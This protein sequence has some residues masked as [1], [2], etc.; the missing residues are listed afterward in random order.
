MPP[1]PDHI[2]HAPRK[3]IC[4]PK[5]TAIP[6]EEQSEIGVIAASAGNHALALAW[7]GKQM[8]IPVTVLMPT[9]APLAKVSRCRAFGA[10]VVIHG[11]NIG[12]AKLLAETDPEFA[13]LQYINGYD[14]PEIV[15]GAG[16]MGRNFTLAP[17]P[18]RTSQTPSAGRTTTS[19]TRRRWI[20]L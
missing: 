11:A 1:L 20:T 14:D 3:H 12:E 2:F 6:S 19:R 13:G 9:L 5:L 10:N 7:H 8:G 16:T 17:N 4:S 15:A 18:L